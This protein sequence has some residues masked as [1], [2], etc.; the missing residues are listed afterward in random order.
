MNWKPKINAVRVSIPDFP[1][2]LLLEAKYED[3]SFFHDDAPDDAP[4]GCRIGAAK[5]N[6]GLCAGQ[7]AQNVLRG[8]RQRRAGG[9][10]PRRVHDH[11][12]TTGPGGSASFPKRG[13]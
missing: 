4:V 1:F 8:P 7:R 10:A 13:K 5:T 11:H 6:D 2:D 9:V 12:Q 3:N